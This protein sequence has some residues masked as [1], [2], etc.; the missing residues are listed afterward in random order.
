MA[1]HL[2]RIGENRNACRI[3]EG[4]PDGMELGGSP[5][6]KNNIKMDLE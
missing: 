4:K 3:L 5:I 6:W 1:M 2:A